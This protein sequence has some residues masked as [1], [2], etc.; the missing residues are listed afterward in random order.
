MQISDSDVNLY[1]GDINGNISGVKVD[2][3]M[4]NVDIKTLTNGQDKTDVFYLRNAANITLGGILS[5]TPRTSIE[6]F[7]VCGSVDDRYRMGGVLV[8]NV[9]K[10][11]TVIYVKC[12]LPNQFIVGDLILLS[13]DFQEYCVV[14]NV[15]C[16]DQLHVISIV[17]EIKYQ[18]SEGCVIGSSVHFSLQSKFDIISGEEF[19]D[20]SLISIT[21]EGCLTHTVTVSFNDDKN[22]SVISNLYGIL[23]N[24]KKGVLYIATSTVF[25]WLPMFQFSPKCFEKA[26]KTSEIK[27]A[28]TGA[29]I[30][31][32]RK[33]KIDP[34]TKFDLWELK[35]GFIELEVS[36]MDGE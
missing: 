22:Y 13:D 29:Y 4:T 16:T 27:I 12:D 1:E 15:E 3:V 30:K 35:H 19:T 11:T 18:H 23:G 6:W 10:G 2:T 32:Q 34:N 7:T 14:K 9:E 20:K 5:F 26:T 33:V 28:F 8:G 21:N 24:G 17:N 36:K 31:I 25:P